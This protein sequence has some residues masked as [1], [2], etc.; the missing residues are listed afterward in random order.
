MLKLENDLLTGSLKTSDQAIEI[1]DAVVNGDRLSFSVELPQVQ[2]MILD[3]EAR[4]TAKE[5]RGKVKFS[6]ASIGRGQSLP[7]IASRSDEETSD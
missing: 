2:G 6:I 1:Q 4:I 3:F 7:W 5:L